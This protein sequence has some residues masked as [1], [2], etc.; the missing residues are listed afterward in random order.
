MNLTRHFTLEELTLSQDA[1]RYGIDNEP[2]TEEVAQ[3][4][5]L[6]QMV[7]EPLRIALDRPIVV[8]SGYRCPEVNAMVGGAKR[9]HHVQGRAADI[10]VP[11]ITPLEVCQTI[12]ALDLPFDQTIHEFG[13]WCHVSVA[14]DP[15]NSPQQT[16]TAMRQLGKT[17]YAAGL[18]KVPT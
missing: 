18:H 12:V 2:G 7:L 4:R 13:R 9:S 14:L 11:G 6:C 8:S 3:L 5:R 16:L 15:E 17:V 1:A 10:T